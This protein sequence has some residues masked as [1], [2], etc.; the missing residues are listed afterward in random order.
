MRNQ[1]H[2][3]FIVHRWQIES[4]HYYNARLPAGKTN[5]YKTAQDDTNLGT[6]QQNVPI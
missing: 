6:F 3:G 1:F 2:C 5:G 4:R